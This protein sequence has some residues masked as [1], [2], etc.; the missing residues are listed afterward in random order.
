MYVHCT[1]LKSI[2]VS[3]TKVCIFI[4][5]APKKYNLGIEY[6]V[7]FS[8]LLLMLFTKFVQ[9][10]TFRTCSSGITF[11]I[12]DV[13]FAQINCEFVLNNTQKVHFY[14]SEKN[15]AKKVP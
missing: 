7:F 4:L 6:G 3:P 13:E 2:V 10:S 15:D 12:Y 5:I 9:N 1:F 14:T 8:A 11:E